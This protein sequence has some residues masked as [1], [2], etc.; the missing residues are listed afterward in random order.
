MT[1]RL[2]QMLTAYKQKYDV[3]AKDLAAEIG[4]SESA[5]CR[6][7]KGKMP[8]ARGL[9]LIMMWMTDER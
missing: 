8:D 4:V 6:W 7:C 3:Q 2:G 9:S 1:S 5:L